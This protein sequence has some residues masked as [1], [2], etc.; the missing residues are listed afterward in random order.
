[1][2]VFKYNSPSDD[3]TLAYS[4]YLLPNLSSFIECDFSKAQLLA[5]A[6]QGSGKGFVVTLNQWRPYY[7]ASYGE[8]GNHCN[9]GLMRV[10]AVPWPHIG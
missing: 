6:T 1:M 3:N 10:L 4:V 7:F 9:D 8:D 2:A 5:N